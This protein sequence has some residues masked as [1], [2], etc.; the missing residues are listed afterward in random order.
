MYSEQQEYRLKHA[1]NASGAAPASV[2]RVREII[3]DVIRDRRLGEV[4]LLSIS[5]YYPKLAFI[6][7]MRVY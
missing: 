1:V 7:D 5:F 6:F 2:D 3:D 4:S